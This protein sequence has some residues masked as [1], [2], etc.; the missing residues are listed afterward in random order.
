MHKLTYEFFST[1]S[2]NGI[3]MVIVEIIQYLLVIESLD[4]NKVNN[5]L[6]MYH[7]V[8]NILVMKIKLIES[9][10]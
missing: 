5:I 6:K 1:S 3:I 9:R 7:C 8:R 10:N 2:Y 4:K